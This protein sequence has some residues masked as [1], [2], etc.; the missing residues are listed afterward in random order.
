[1]FPGVQSLGG[2]IHQNYDL[3]LRYSL[4]ITAE[5]DFRVRHCLMA[6]PGVKL[7][8]L[9][10]VTSHVQALAQCDNHLREWGLTAE[11]GYDTAGSAKLIAE[12]KE[13][14]VAAIASEHAAGTYGLEVHP[15]ACKFA[16]SHQRLACQLAPL[17]T[18]HSH[19]RHIL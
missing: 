18:A 11:P 13:T 10:R 2:S 8:D 14:E 12:R 17:P 4:N 15:C 5:I 19:A 16:A 9:K 7:A 6:M 3:L 1:M